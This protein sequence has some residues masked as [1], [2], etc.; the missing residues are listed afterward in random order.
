MSKW[1]NI[2][3]QRL[4]QGYR[5]YCS[6]RY[7][8]FI[9]VLL[10][11]GK[12]NSFAEEGCGIGTFS[13]ILFN[14]FETVIRMTDVDCEMIKLAKSSCLALSNIIE[15]SD[16]LTQKYS[17]NKRPDIIFSHGV[18]EHFEDFEIKKIIKRQLRDANKYVIHYIPTDKWI[19]P[20]CGDERLL[21]LDKWQELTKFNDFRLFNNCKDAVLVW[22]V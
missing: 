9:D 3:S 2:Y 7:K 14:K 11:K 8:T 13:G 21:S 1:S 22:K 4:G 6:I 20:S 17:K 16:I 5:E 12:F 19:I 10:S 15:E 18:L